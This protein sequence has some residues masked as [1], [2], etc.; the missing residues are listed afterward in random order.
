[1]I[2]SRTAKNTPRVTP[3]AGSTRRISVPAAMPSAIANSE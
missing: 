3:S 2:I 1:M